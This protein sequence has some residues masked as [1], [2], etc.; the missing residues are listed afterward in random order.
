[1]SRGTAVG[2]CEFCGGS[3]MD[4]PC[5]LKTR[6]FCSGRCRN[7]ARA[8]SRTRINGYIFRLVPGHPAAMRHG[9]VAEHRLVAE[10]A[11]GK[12]L[13]DTAVVHHHNEDPTD[14]R[15]ENLVICQD[16]SYHL[17]LHMRM[18]RI[19]K[20][21]E[22]GGDPARDSYCPECHKALPEDQFSRSSGTADGCHT[23]CKPCDARRGARRRAA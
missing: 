21:R 6:R 9:L 16:Q 8:S 4:W 12:I 18:R 3:F 19:R 22:A 7:K 11:L 17:L 20:I 5:K 1:M 23:Y 13:P 15:P 14:N 2:V 10:K